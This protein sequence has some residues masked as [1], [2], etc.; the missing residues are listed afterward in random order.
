MIRKATKEDKPKIL[1]LLHDFYKS[2]DYYF[3]GWNEQSTSTIIDSLIDNDN[4]VLLVNDEVTGCIGGYVVPFW[5]NI[6]KK[7]GQELFW[8]VDKS[9]RG[10]RVAVSLFKNFEEWAKEQDVSFIAMSSTTNLD[11]SGVGSFYKR[12]GYTAS[13]ISYIKKVT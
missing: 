4:S 6:D 12:K 9:I 2:T 13:D 10:S 11:P 1:G 3:L 8:Y 5:M 7:A